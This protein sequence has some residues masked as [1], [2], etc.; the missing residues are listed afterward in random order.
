MELKTY[1]VFTTDKTNPL[2]PK[3]VPMGTVKGYDEEDAHTRA[4]LYNNVDRDRISVAILA[5][6]PK[7]G[8]TIH[9]TD[10]DPNG[11]A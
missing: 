11:V 8:F 3:T 6:Q 1:A 9:D 7:P 10:E 4:T 5:I 2:R